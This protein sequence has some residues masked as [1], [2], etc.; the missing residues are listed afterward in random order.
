[1]FLF[2]SSYFYPNPRLHYP[3][4][5]KHPECHYNSAQGTDCLLIV[6]SFSE[7]PFCMTGTTF[8][9]SSS[10]ARVK[11]R[12]TISAADIAAGRSQWPCR[13]RRDCLRSLGHWD[14]GFESHSRHECLCAFILCLCCSVCR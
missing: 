9:Y 5:D 12:D 11:L 13:L 6:H 10:V 14:R 4:I 2:L 7:M 1:M 8:S 3:F